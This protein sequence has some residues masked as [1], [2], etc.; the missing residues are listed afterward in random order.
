MKL[1]SVGKENKE[2]GAT[3]LEYAL[4][5]SLIGVVVIPVVTSTGGKSAGQFAI[6]TCAIACSKPGSGRPKDNAFSNPANCARDYEWLSSNAAECEGSK[7]K[8]VCGS[9]T[10]LRRVAQFCG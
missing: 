6:S 9:K 3:M 10:L 2:K 1:F 4:L 7:D 8:W 5:A